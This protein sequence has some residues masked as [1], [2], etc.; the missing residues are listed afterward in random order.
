MYSYLLPKCTILVVIQLNKVL[1]GVAAHSEYVQVTKCD[2]LVG[3]VERSI[4]QHICL[5]WNI[6]NLQWARDLVLPRFNTGFLKNLEI[7]A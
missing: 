1:I 3:S 2:I 5:I 4:D 6:C 7:P